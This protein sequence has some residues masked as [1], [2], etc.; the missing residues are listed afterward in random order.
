MSELL[1]R[2]VQQ[3]ELPEGAAFTKRNIWRLLVAIRRGQLHGPH[4]GPPLP[5]LQVARRLPL[6][7]PTP[8]LL[9]SATGPR[10]RSALLLTDGLQQAGVAC[11][12]I[13]RPSL[14]EEAISIC[15]FPPRRLN[16]EPGK[17]LALLQHKLQLLVVPINA[18]T[19]GAV[20]NGHAVPFQALAGGRAAPV[21]L[22]VR[23]VA[24]DGGVAV[25]QGLL[26]LA[27]ELQQ[28][29]RA[30]GVQQAP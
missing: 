11:K 13:R 14:L 29:V 4:R 23:G 7:D 12:S 8:E 18:E 1:L 5:E 15:L 10:W 17:G 20:S 16:V 6:K 28:H 25:H 24:L 2:A 26:L 30:V 9:N 3:A 19:P 21:R 22:H 27:R